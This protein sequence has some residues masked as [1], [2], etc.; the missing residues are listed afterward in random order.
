MYVC[1]HTYNKTTHSGC[2]EGYIND[3][4]MIEG[5]ISGHARWR[6]QGKEEKDEKGPEDEE[7]MFYV[8]KVVSR[9]GLSWRA[10][11]RA[12]VGPICDD[13]MYVVFDRALATMHHTRWLK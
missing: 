7:L 12:R 9:N 4:G 3:D 6:T 10:G 11:S 1:V 5:I 8:V 13:S 2:N